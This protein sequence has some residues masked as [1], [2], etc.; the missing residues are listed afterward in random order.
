MVDRT[1][2]GPDFPEIRHAHRPVAVD[3]RQVAGKDR[4]T[5]ALTLPEMMQKPC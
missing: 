2:V 4:R 5:T 1:G 3:S